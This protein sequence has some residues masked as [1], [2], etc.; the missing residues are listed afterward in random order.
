M[1]EGRLGAPALGGEPSRCWCE[2]QSGLEG[3]RAGGS[4]LDP[5]Y[6]RRPGPHRVTVCSSEALRCVL[7]AVAH[8]QGPLGR[9]PLRIR[10]AAFAASDSRA[11]GEPLP[12]GKP[13]ALKG[14]D[15]RGPGTPCL[16]G[17]LV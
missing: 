2:V 10:Q 5:T 11:C 9:P 3:L 8:T 14:G 13:A 1:T 15:G 17:A 4:V 6:A 16:F 12:S 7:A